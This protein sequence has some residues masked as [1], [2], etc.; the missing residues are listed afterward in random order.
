ME[1][2]FTESPKSELKIKKIKSVLRNRE[3]EYYTA[4]GLFSM[5]KVDKGSEL[6]IKKSLIK[7]NSKILDLGCGYGIIGI[8]L[9]LTINNIQVTF[10]DINERAI[11]IT[12]K[13]LRLNNLKAETIQ[14]NGFEKISELFEVILLNPPQTAGRDLCFK[15]I[16][17][18]KKHLKEKGTLQIVARHNKGGKELSKKM[19]EIFN[20]VKDISKQAGYRIYLSQNS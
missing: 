18:S 10:S 3:I 13:N 7:E 11:E 14:S 4:S 15:L 2:Y 20:N 19:L 12:K 16:E 8:S 5:K 17:D 6:L 9:L 1:H